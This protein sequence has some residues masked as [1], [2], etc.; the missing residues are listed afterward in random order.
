MSRGAVIVCWYAGLTPAAPHILQMAVARR[1]CL[2][3]L[4]EV[5]G[6]LPPPP[7][8]QLLRAVKTLTAD[9]AVLTTLYVGATLR[10]P[11]THTPAAHPPEIPR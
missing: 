10:P 5:A 4:I 3:K 2:L 11:P 6:A 9:P 1:D 8:L 7:A